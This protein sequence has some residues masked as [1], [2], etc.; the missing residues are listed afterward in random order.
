MMSKTHVAIGM[1]TS[2]LLL[3]PTNPKGCIAAIIGGLLVE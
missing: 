1:A 2:L 3:Q